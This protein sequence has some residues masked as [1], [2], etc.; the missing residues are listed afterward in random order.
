MDVLH[1]PGL[2][3]SAAWL[4]ADLQQLDAS[5]EELQ[6]AGMLVDSASGAIDWQQYRDD[7]P[8][9]LAALVEAKVAGRELVAPAEEPLQVINLLDALKQSVAHAQSDAGA[10]ARSAA[11]SG[12]RQ[13]RSA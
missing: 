13:R 5:P 1:D 3:R 12:Q 8:D 10:G 4:E 7:T 11:A 6:L 2:L 9:K